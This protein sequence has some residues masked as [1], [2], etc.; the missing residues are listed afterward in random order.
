MLN[1][2]L[3]MI[4]ALL[5]ASAVIAAVSHAPRDESLSVMLKDFCLSNLRPIHAWILACG[6][7]QL[8]FWGKQFRY[9]YL[10]A[11]NI[12]YNRRPVVTSR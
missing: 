9:W 5:F 11:I 1:L 3:S 10:S 12:L 6:L 2:V 8:N 4:A 7:W